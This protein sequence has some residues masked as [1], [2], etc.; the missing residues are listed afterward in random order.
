MQLFTA[1]RNSWELIIT[2]ARV[3]LESSG[4]YDE[5]PCLLAT[6]PRPDFDAKAA[7]LETLY[8]TSLTYDIRELI[9]SQF[10]D[11]RQFGCFSRRNVIAHATLWAQMALDV[12]AL[13][14]DASKREVARARCRF[15]LLRCYYRLGCDGDY[16]E[17]AC[18]R[19]AGVRIPNRV[20]LERC[21][22]CLREEE[23]FLAKRG[24]MG[25]AF[26]Y[27]RLIVNLFL[28]AS[29]AQA[30]AT[31]RAYQARDPGQ[32]LGLF[33]FVCETYAEAIDGTNMMNTCRWTR[34]KVGDLLDM[35]AAVGL[36]SGDVDLS[37]RLVS[38]AKDLHGHYRVGQVC[39]HHRSGC[40][41]WWPFDEWYHTSLIGFLTDEGCAEFRTRAEVWKRL[42][43]AVRSALLSGGNERLQEFIEQ[44]SSR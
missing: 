44:L 37:D 2:I 30:S 6:E 10:N 7:K 22:E 4:T 34:Q 24:M 33:D 42:P 43:L 18:R 15:E 19:L 20:A 40:R 31:Y 27:P 3:I 25:T 11:T 36:A 5:E 29:E 1:N 28:F 38:L 41:E 32:K 14:T 13:T 8:E 39:R 23:E 12:A 9:G 26:F 35:A 17:T 16:R 21:V